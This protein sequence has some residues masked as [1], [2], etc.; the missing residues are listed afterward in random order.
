MTRKLNAT[1][2]GHD[3]DTQ[4]Y[5]PQSDPKIAAAPGPRLAGASDVYAALLDLRHQDREHFVAFDLNARHRVI[6]RRI[7][8][9]GTLTGVEVHPRE[10]FKPAILNSA[11]ALIV[12]HNHPSGDAS[13][14]AMDV[15]MTERL[16]QAGELLGIPVLDHVVFAAEGYVS[17][18]DRNWRG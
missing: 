1:T 4:P 15:A 3:V 7:V 18:A 12:A 17:L 6:A 16:R 9:I 14:S 5:R 10:V 13:P 11:C 8:H 2:A